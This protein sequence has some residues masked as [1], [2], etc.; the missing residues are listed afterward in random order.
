VAAA[1]RVE[2]GQVTA[3]IFGSFT[4]MVVRV[5]DPGFVTAKVYWIVSPT[6]T[7]PLPLTSVGVPALLTSPSRA[8]PELLLEVLFAAV[9]SASYPVT[10]PVLTTP[11]V[12]LAGTEA[13]SVYVVVAPTTSR[14]PTHRTVSPV[15]VHP[16][17]VV[18]TF[19]RGAGTTSVMTW[20]L[21]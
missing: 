1:A 6:S 20:P 12:A 17:V 3:P 18:A 15:T 21:D 10:V 8:S 11:E 4:A 13:V 19:V 5:T 7:R 16:A 9:G 2:E 14:P